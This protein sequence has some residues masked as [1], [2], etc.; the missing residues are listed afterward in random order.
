MQAFNSD[1]KD[2]IK[3][4]EPPNL[5]RER[6]TL[7]TRTAEA[8]DNLSSIIEALRSPQGCPWDAAQTSDTLKPFLLEETYEVL[9][10]IDSGDPTAIRE[11]LGDLLMQIVFHARIFEERQLFNLA[12]VA[13]EISQKLIRRH[14][15]VFEKSVELDHASLRAQ[16]DH[17]KSQ[18]KT[19]KNKN[20]H[21]FSGI[22][23]NLPA[24]AR[25]RKV[26]ERTYPK[27]I[28]P[29]DQKKAWDEV[30]QRLEK[31]KDTQ[32]YDQ[33]QTETALGETLFSLARLCY[34]SRVD[35]EEALRKATNRYMSSRLK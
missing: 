3:S 18:E 27:E 2:C 21:Q 17:I 30:A 6:R 1:P 29:L 16:W 33:Q 9:E 28:G 15:H 32:Q 22:P 26:M 8:I 25:A 12:D 24:L 20:P 10:A 31:L 23:A 35:P 4:K 19:R 11:E 13:N 7:M 5:Q 14:P 34:V